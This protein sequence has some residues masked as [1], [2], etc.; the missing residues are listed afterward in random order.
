M[1]RLAHK[2]CGCSNIKHKL[3]A[4]IIKGGTIRATGYN[5]RSFDGSIHA[6]IDAI[7]KMRF[8]KGGSQGCDLYVYRFHADGG[9]ALAKPCVPCMEKIIEV[10]IKRVFYSDNDNE[11]R[12][13][14]IGGV[15]LNSYTYG[16]IEISNS[17]YEPFI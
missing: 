1:D 2:L 7:R 6:E 15:D 14:N 8:Q 3:A 11:M 13:I 16:V 10:G 4:F 17:S 9:Y 12:M 5:K